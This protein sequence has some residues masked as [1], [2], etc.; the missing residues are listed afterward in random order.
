MMHESL[1][2]VQ[3]DFE[4]CAV[5]GFDL[6][7]E[8]MEQGFDFAPVN[9]GARRILK[10]AAHQVCMLVAH[11]DAPKIRTTILCLSLASGTAR[12]LR[13]TVKKG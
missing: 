5:R 3:R 1:N 4:A 11:D 8:M 6:G 10:D 2:L 12:M 13:S 7:A 9:V